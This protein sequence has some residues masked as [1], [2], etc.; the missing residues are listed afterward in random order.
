M[1]IGK[2]TIRTEQDQLIDNISSELQSTRNQQLGQYGS[3]STDTNASAITPPAGMV[4]IAVQFHGNTRLAALIAENATN[5]TTG[6]A[7][8]GTTTTGSGSGGVVMDTSNK[9]ASGTMIYGR[10][11]SLTVHT[12]VGAGHAVIA[13]FGY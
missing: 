6:G 8:F 2:G 1:T 5:H 12:T 13:Y 9:F 11:T 10:W 7:S 3:A 4:I